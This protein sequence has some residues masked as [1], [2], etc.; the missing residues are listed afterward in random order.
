MCAETLVEERAAT[1]AFALFRL[2]NVSYLFLITRSGRSTAFLF[3][4]VTVG[5]E[6]FWAGDY[7]KASSVFILGY[8]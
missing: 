6:I 7:T 5:K 8:I 2:F 3:G 4:M 1:L